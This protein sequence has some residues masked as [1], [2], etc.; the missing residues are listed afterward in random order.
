MKSER[1]PAPAAGRGAGRLLLFL[2]LA[3]LFGMHALTT[4]GLTCESATG[5]SD[6]GTHATPHLDNQ[7]TPSAGFATPLATG[8][9]VVALA[10]GD[11]ADGPGA[12]AGGS[13]PCG[14]LGLCLAVLAI[15][16]LLLTGWRRGRPRILNVRPDAP[17]T[18]VARGRQHRPAPSLTLLCVNR[19]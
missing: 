3:G 1:R 12:G 8:A 10:V 11:V 19:C 15:A 16:L 18:R 9:A 13:G 6:P 5:G 7:P 4:H 14:V 2:V 17:P